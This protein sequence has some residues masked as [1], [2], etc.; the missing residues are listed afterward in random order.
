MMKAFGIST[1]A[2]LA[3]L[4]FACFS[5]PALQAQTSRG[6]VTGSITDP[7]KASV[8]NVKVELK[9]SDTN[10]VRTSSTNDAG[11][12]RF[13]AVDPGN[14]QISAVAQGFRASQTTPFDVT[15]GQLA[16]LDLKLEVGT[17][18]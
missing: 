13:D 2:A 15:G 17:Q 4:V 6:T 18:T 8:P 7:S 5:S 12:Y 14:Y 3:S 9:N 1:G 11:L 16:S 10:V